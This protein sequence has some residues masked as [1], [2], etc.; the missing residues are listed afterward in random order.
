MTQVKDEKIFNLKLVDFARLIG[1]TAHDLPQESC[2]II[3]KH[4]F[5]YR[6][7]SGRNRERLIAKIIKKIDSGDLTVAGRERKHQWEKGWRENIENFKKKDFDERE[8]VPK[9]I[10]PNQVVRLMGEYVQPKDPNFELNFSR[11]FKIWLF[12]KF[13][14]KHK[15]IYE[16]GSGSAVNLAICATLFPSKNLY[17]LDWVMSS[18]KIIDLMVKEKGWNIKGFLFDM[19]VPKPSFRIEPDSAILLFSSLE[20]LG[21]DFR[22]FV[23]FLIQQ[24]VSMVVHVDSL[25]E[26]YDQNS[27]FDYLALK[28]TKKRN[29][30]SMYLTYMHKLEREGEVKILKIHRVNFGSLYLDGYSYDIW[31]PTKIN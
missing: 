20:Q 24:K 10:R 7:I 22:P 4:E 6:K 8:L 9:Y 5:G 18:K 2:A 30:L 25:E 27:M 23:N 11:A 1:T 3:N 19:F 12:K 13:L 29:Y 28:F 15:N 26:L 17:G 16:F 21:S 31:R 14:I